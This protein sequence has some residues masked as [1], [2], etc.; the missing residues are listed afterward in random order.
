[1]DDCRNYVVSDVEPIFEASPALHNR[2]LVESNKTGDRSTI[3][4]RQFAGG[5]LKIVPSRSPRN[6]RAHT[7]RVLLVDEADAMNMSD[8]GNPIRLA[9]R[10][11]LSFAD[12]KRA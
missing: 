8:E 4:H 5:S 2:L 11:T 1:L 3:L 6:L 12:R 10:R 9:E 7:A